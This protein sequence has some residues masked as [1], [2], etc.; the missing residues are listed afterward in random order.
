MKKLY[1]SPEIEFDS[2]DLSEYICRELYGDFY[3]V[4]GNDTIASPAGAS[5]ISGGHGEGGMGD[6]NGGVGGGDGW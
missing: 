6:G 2:F 1:Q 5:Q 4:G 3:S